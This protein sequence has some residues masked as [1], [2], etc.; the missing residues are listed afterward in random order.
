MMDIAYEEHL[1]SKNG[2]QRKEQLKE[3]MNENFVR[4]TLGGYEACDI[5]NAGLN[6]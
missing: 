4:R 3:I 1:R 5:E 2:G 6:Q